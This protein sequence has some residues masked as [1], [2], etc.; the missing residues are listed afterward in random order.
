M[1][2]LN[3]LTRALLYTVLAFWTLVQSYV[4][5]LMA[6]GAFTAPVLALLSF[7]NKLPPA[8]TDRWWIIYL[9]SGIPVG[10]Y[11]LVYLIKH[12]VPRKS[13]QDKK[14]GNGNQ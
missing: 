13:K 14:Q 12:L 2:A 9:L 1:K 3:K 11:S 7:I 6:G 4:I 10:L 5:G 8:V